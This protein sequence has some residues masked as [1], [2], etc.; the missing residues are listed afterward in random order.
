M[1]GWGEGERIWL[2]WNES[3][4]GVG[5]VLCREDGVCTS[6]VLC[7]NQWILLSSVHWRGEEREGEGEEERERE[8]EGGREDGLVSMKK[9][10]ESILLMR[11]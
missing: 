8:R 9:E 1:L 7:C 5:D 3:V 2:V 6:R 11:K 10:E 4:V